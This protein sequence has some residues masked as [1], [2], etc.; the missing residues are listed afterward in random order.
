[1]VCITVAQKSVQQREHL[2]CELFL[3]DTHV[4]GKFNL[5]LNIYLKMT[6]K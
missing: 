5:T 2:L 4:G 6:Q 1:M 3:W